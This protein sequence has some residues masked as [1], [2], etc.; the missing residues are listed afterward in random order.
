VNT[1]PNHRITELFVRYWDGS[2]T[3]TE[4]DELEQR[5]ATDPAARERFQALALHEVAAADRRTAPPDTGLPSAG[6][7][8][9]DPCS[10]DELTAAEP[11]TVPERART[12]ISDAVVFSS[13]GRK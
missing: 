8:W 4:A 11:E 9:A 12:R 5:L 1:P 10:A 2:L 3:S 7:P 13:V 6:R